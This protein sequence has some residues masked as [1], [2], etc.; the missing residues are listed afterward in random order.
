MGDFIVAAAKD[1][2]IYNLLELQMNLWRNYRGI[3]VNIPG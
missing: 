1:Y 2:A 3:M